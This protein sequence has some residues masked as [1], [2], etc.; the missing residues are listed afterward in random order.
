MLAGAPGP[1]AYL[2]EVRGSEG[3]TL[4]RH[5]DQRP[6]RQW[7][8]TPVLL[9]TRDTGRVLVDTDGTTSSGNLEFTRSFTFNI[10]MNLSMLNL[11]Y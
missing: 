11:I 10:D 5:A 2:P 1:R 8:P 3:L 9:P 4:Q 7:H 6:R